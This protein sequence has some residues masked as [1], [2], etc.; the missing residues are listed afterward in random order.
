MTLFESEI[1]EQPAALARQLDRGRD[2]AE[3]VA[4]EIRRFAPR[5]VMMAARGTSDNAARYAQYLLG[6]HNRLAVG[7]AA[8]SLFTLYDAPPRVDGALVVGISQSGQSPDIV[9]VVEEA[10]SQG[11]L[12]LAITNDPSSPLARAALLGLPVHAGE[13]HAVA[14]TKTYTTELMALAMLSAALEGDAARWGELAE[15]PEHVGAAL[16]QRES[17]SLAAAR[18]REAQRFVVL[19]RGFNYATAFEVALKIKETSYVLAEPYSTADFRHGPA[20]MLELGFPVLV[21]ALR[22]K[23]GDA[24]ALLDLLEARR[25]DVLAISNDPVLLGRAGC[26]LPI[27]DV[28]EWLSPLVAVVPGQWFALALALSR[29]ADPDRPRGLSKVTHTR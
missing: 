3:A 20:A 14:A 11:A 22:G 12:T 21:V 13:E 24:G 4:R 26:A 7:L 18:C 2:D 1:L 9:A 8:P 15:V 5:W 17:A 23:V 16:A 6:V 19:G 10:R 28:P 27:P 25:A 29:G